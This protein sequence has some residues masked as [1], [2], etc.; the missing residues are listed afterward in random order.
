MLSCIR[1]LV[2]CARRA[3]S[4]DA[5]MA[6]RSREISTAMMAM[7]TKSSISVKPGRRPV[8]GCM[9]SL[10]AFGEGSL[11]RRT[12]IRKRGSSRGSV[13]GVVDHL[14]VVAVAQA[15]EQLGLDGLAEEPDR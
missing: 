2:H 15:P 3:A 4:R 11:G 6:G 7:T 1:L 9:R 5:W 10:P 13:A 14:A 12:A 8:G